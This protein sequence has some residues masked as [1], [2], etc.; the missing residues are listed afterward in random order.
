M[1]KCRNIVEIKQLTSWKHLTYRHQTLCQEW[2]VLMNQLSV[3]WRLVKRFSTVYPN[4]CW[5]FKFGYSYSLIS[6]EC[7]HCIKQFGNHSYFFKC[8]RINHH[9]W[10][11]TKK[12]IIKWPVWY[13]CE[14]QSPLIQFEEKQS[15]TIKQ[16][17]LLN[18]FP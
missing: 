9:S 6:V 12:T 14:Q 11:R 13:K 7:C 3:K 10:I 5:L 1:Q 2:P 17:N 16:N 4:K 18:I 15:V 8:W